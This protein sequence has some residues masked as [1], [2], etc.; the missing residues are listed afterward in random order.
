MLT[1][2]AMSWY[3]TNNIQDGKNGWIKAQGELSMKK[4]QGIGK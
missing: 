4:T 2:D 1:R 3:N